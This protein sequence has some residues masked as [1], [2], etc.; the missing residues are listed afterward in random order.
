LGWVMD[1]FRKKIR[2][3]CF[4]KVV[5]YFLTCCMVLN[6][7]LPAAL[8]VVPP[9]SDALP[10]GGS[11]PTG[12]GSVGNFDYSITGELHVRNVAEKTVINW[13]NFDVGSDALLIS[14]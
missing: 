6:T 10:S 12:Y 4:R 8:A 3:R 7:S 14:T 9:A 13:D 2:I 11:V 1:R 5:I